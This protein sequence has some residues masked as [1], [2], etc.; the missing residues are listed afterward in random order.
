MKFAFDTGANS[1]VHSARIDVEFEFNFE[2]AIQ[3]SMCRCLPPDS[4]GCRHGSEHGEEYERCHGSTNFGEFTHRQWVLRS[5]LGCL[6]PELADK[7]RMLDASTN[8]DYQGF[9][10]T[11]Q[12]RGIPTSFRR[13]QNVDEFMRIS[14]IF[15]EP[16]EPG[17]PGETGETSAKPRQTHRAK[18][19]EMT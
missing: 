13:R 18:L 14:R 1:A 16:G 19:R 9:C 10:S 6:K 12:S 4:R 11:P 15:R 3:L 7:F 2:I 17:E 5:V 8:N